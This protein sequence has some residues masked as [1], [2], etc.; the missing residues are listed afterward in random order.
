MAGGGNRTR[1]LLITNQVLYQLSYTGKIP[2]CLRKPATRLSRG[3]ALY[4]RRV[5][6]VKEIPDGMTI[7]PRWRAISYSRTPAETDA[8]RLPT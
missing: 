2:N 7:Q 3:G 5:W 6:Q 8:L 1:D 4:P